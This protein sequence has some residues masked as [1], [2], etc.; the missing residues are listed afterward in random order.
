MYSVLE[1]KNANIGDFWGFLEKN[2]IK[3]LLTV[4]H[5]R[6]APVCAPCQAL[7]YLDDFA[8]SEYLTFF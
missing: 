7:P 5:C 3:K 8:L 6:G 1:F 4:A 2:V